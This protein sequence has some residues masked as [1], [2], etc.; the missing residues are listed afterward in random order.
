MKHTKRNMP[1]KLKHKIVKSGGSLRI[2]IPKPICQQLGLESGTTL[3]IW[4][5]DEN[6]ICLR[7]EEAKK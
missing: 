3:E 5:N 1:L 7:K 6:V 2:L 4:L